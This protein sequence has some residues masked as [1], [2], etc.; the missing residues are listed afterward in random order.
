MTTRKQVQHQSSESSFVHLTEGDR[1]Y[2][3]HA[4]KDGRSVAAIAQRLG[5][6]R[7]TIYRELD[8]NSGKY[9]YFHKHAHQKAT[10][11]KARLQNYRSFTSEI[12]GRV[13]EW[14]S[15]LWSPEQIVGYC[16]RHGIEM[17]SVQTI[18]TYIH[19]DRKAGGKL[20]LHCRHKASIC[21]RG[22]YPSGYKFVDQRTFITEMPEELRSKDVFGIIEADTII[23]K[24]GLSAMLT[25]CERS[26][27]LTLI[28][29]LPEGKAAEPLAKALVLEL[30]PF[31]EKLKAIIMDNGIEF[32]AFK[33]IIKRLGIP[34]YFARPYTSND[35][36]YIEQTN[37][38][39]RQYFE[40]GIPLDTFSY[41]IVKQ[42]QQ[43]L[44]NRPRK[45]LNYQTPTQVFYRAFETD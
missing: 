13:R 39:I 15:Q 1:Q 32:T 22:A 10:G 29:P 28:R 2:I 4:L 11:R 21:P 17:V 6:H 20:Y 23:G 25:L 34:V 8:R 9:G 12:R 33:Y 3:D 30:L 40:K 36:P 35:K 45:K 26:S 18:Y 31:K 16:N 5:K 44:N 14:L 38:L 24:N 27:N 43:A 37:K 41:E 42:V 7:C 19:Q